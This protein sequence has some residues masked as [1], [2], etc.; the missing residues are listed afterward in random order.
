VALEGVTFLTVAWV[1]RPVPESWVER[2]RPTRLNEVVGNA[3]ALRAIG[4]WADSW[5]EGPPKQRALLLIGAPGCGKTSAAIALAAERGWGVIELNASDARSQDAIRRVAGHGA[6]HE[7]F[8]DDGAYFSSRK[9]QRKL[10]IIDEADNLYERGSDA[11]DAGVDYSDRGGKRAI[12]ETIAATR[13]PIILIVNDAYALTRGAGSPVNRLALK[14][15]FAAVSA[16]TIAG[17]LARICRQE[18]LEAQPAALE[19]IAARA[20]GDL[21]SAVNDLQA[22]GEGRTRLAVDDLEALGY[23]NRTESV[24]NAL[25]TILRSGDAQ[26]AVE[27]TWDLDEAPADLLTWIDENVPKEYRDP[28][29]LVAAYDALS[30]ADRFL[31]RTRRRQAFRLWAYASQLMTG[32]VAAARTQRAG[33]FVRYGF[34]TWLRQMSSSKGARGLRDGAA[35]KVAGHMHAS[36]RIVVRDVIPWLRALFLADR[37]VAEDVSLRM[38]LDGDEIAFVYG[39][40]AE[41]AVVEDVAAHVERRREHG[42]AEADPFFTEDEPADAPEPNGDGVAAPDEAPDETEE[43]SKTLFDF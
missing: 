38:G 8:S 29:D 30:R 18:G 35:A 17:V 12:V 14:V 20:E 16:A 33:G 41:K 15:P 5:A 34:P 21:R 22:M 7:T 43:P 36:K 9:G 2:Y 10:I 1:A 3:T 6:M 25:R 28:T 37:A 11:T 19:S 39:P 31:G 26:A 24:F 4:R 42:T 27:S 40:D 32:G 23:R 13:Q